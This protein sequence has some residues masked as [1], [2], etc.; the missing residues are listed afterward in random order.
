[1]QVGAAN[2]ATLA[3]GEYWRLITSQFLHV[4]F[5]H[6]VANLVGVYVLASAVERSAGRMAVTAIYLLGGSIGQYCSVL[7]RPE[8]VNSGAS[9]ALMAL[10]GF[11]LFARK[12]LAL[13]YYA[14]TTSVII[15]LIQVSLDVYA[16]GGIKPGHSF[17]LFA[18][19]AIAIIFNLIK[20]SQRHDG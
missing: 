18:G 11:M 2:G 16:S 4:H 7:S 20:S 1:M 8:L 15:I 13:P 14:I 6:M 10:C 17:G 5:L 9:Q 19:M 3:N 12:S